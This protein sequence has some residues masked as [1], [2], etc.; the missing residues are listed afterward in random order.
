[1]IPK[2]TFIFLFFFTSMAFSQ[3][4]FGI[5]AGLNVSNIDYNVSGASPEGRTGYFFGTLVDFPLAG[6]FHLQAEILY[7]REGIK[8]GRVD[9]L[10]VPVS[11]KWYF[12]EGIHVNAGP[13]LGV[14]IDAEDG[15]NGL[16]TAMLAGVFGLGFETSEGFT[17]DTRYTMGA[18]SVIDRDIMVDSGRGYNISGIQ[19]WT[20]TFQLGIGY[21][22]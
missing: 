4:N 19:G 11:L 21:K 22:F 7:S 15:T 12:A 1:M 3:V 6:D 18:T 16:N 20:R 17:V 10:N 13:Q 14:V 5:K 2:L 8:D 9:F